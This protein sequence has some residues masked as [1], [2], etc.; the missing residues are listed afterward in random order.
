MVELFEP[1]EQ[2]ILKMDWALERVSEKMS[3]KMSGKP[4]LEIMK[5]IAQDG[6]MTISEL[7]KA[8]ELSQRTIERAL[9]SLQ[10]EG[11]L[12]RIG[13]AKGGVWHVLS[14]EAIKPKAKTHP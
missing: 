6:N 3:E 12:E 2:S 1:Y 10:A 11:R 14:N 4:T 5:L 9:K 7:A 13:P 8:L